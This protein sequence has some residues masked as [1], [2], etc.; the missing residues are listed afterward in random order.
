[1]LTCHQS[2]GHSRRMATRGRP[3]TSKL[4]RSEQLQRAKRRQRVRQHR[5][6]LVHVQLTLPQQ[7]AAKLAV[8][9]Q[10][11]GFLEFLNAALDQAVIRIDEY[12][13]LA[14]LAWNRTEPWI[15]AREAFNLYERNWRLVSRTGL[16]AREREL[17]E[18]LAREYGG[19]VIH[20]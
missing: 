16:I 3:I 9:R 19:G 10:S 7:T 15:A 17:I 14:D 12:P 6:G 20:A 2:E 1:M 18:R 8:A 11:K 5:A 13:A 4:S